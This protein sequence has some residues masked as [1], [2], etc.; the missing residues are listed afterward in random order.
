MST[1]SP[2]MAKLCPSK[3][4]ALS[5]LAKKMVEEGHDVISFAVGEPDFPT[6][7][8]VSQAAIEAIQSGF[9]RY[10]QNIGMSVLRKAISEKLKRRSAPCKSISD[11]F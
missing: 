7:H 6:P 1:L 8:K 4:V 3:T 11:T 9:T 5:D 10:T 2:V